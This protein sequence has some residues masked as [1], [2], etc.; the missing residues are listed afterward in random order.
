[1]CNASAT[2]FTGFLA[3]IGVSSK[4]FVPPHLK[5]PFDVLY[6]N[7]DDSYGTVP[8]VGTVDFEEKKYRI[9]PV[10]IIQVSFVCLY[11]EESVTNINPLSR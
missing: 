10:G 9:P 6:Y 3:D 8:Y 11:G 4:N 7:L 1:M 5:I 2:I